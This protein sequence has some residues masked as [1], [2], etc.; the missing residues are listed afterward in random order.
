[1]RARLLNNLASSE[2]AA[3]AP[4]VALSLFA[5]IGVGG[6]AFDYSRMATLDSELQA[7]ADQAA[8]S[9]A[10][11]LDGKADSRARATAAAQSLIANQTNFANER[12]A[13]PGRAIG[14][15]TV[16]FYSVYNSDDPTKNALAKDDSD[17]HFVQVTTATRQAFFALTPV[18]A[19]LS[20]GNLSGKAVAGL[21]SGVCKVP[22]L[23]ICNPTP[24]ASF[25]A[26]HKVGFGI[27]VVAR[28]SG[29]WSP[30]NFGFLDVGE[31]NNGAPDQ[32][33]AMAY[34]NP[35][36]KCMDI[37][38]NSVNTGDAEPLIDAANT[39]F[40]VYNVPNGSGS[41][42]GNCSSGV[43]PA[44]ANVTKDLVQ[45]TSAT[46]G[47]GTKDCK[48]PKGG[49]D[50]WRL[51]TNQFSPGKKGEVDE[52]KTIDSDSKIDAMGLPRDN[53]HYTSYNSK[54][55]G[56]TNSRIGDG[57]WAR[58]DY[59]NKYHSGDLPPN[60][61]TITRYKTY[62]WEIDNS[63]V[64]N[65]SAGASLSQRGTPVCSSGVLDPSRDRRVL[66]VAIVDNCASLNGTS[67]K[68][69][70][71]Q[72]VDM[73]F[74]EPGYDRGNGAGPTDIYLEVIGETK[75]AGNDSVGSQIVRRDMPYLIE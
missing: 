14:I 47:I 70:V 42:L 58:N 23:M 18:V 56:D 39:R 5:L 64:P 27:Q 34:Q 17:A 40:D 62:R 16:T 7:A 46:V 2:S 8:L 72:W 41:T 32:L 54:G 52:T 12:T 25:D 31:D 48:A 22:P 26:D 4:V 66:S 21:H 71:S 28:K 53:C 74:V 10:T 69:N 60:A 9:A 45:P 37:S 50:G 20:S 29:A 6:I 35:A 75:A 1:M 49:K 65:G 36:L 33:A 15:P 24:G 19:A 43:C 57:K 55:C 59:F 61:S 38:S 68:A 63:K 13:Y 67:V 11:Q 3:V 73:F 30:G 44:A 51:P